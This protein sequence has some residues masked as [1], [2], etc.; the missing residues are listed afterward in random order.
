MTTLFLDE[1]AAETDNAD[2]SEQKVEGAKEEGSGQSTATTE[3]PENE[4][5]QKQAAVAGSFV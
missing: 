4:S 2:A 1:A 3:T 5:A